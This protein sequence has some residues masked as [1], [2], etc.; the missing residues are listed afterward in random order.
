MKPLI[1]LW[2][3]DLDLSSFLTSYPWFSPCLK[4]GDDDRGS[5]AIRLDFVSHSDVTL[6]YLNF[7]RCEQN[8]MNKI[9]WSMIA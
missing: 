1:A 3:E 4:H 9:E 6:L 8:H 7:R 2:S 5:N